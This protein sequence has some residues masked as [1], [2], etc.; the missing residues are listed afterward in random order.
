MPGL[1]WSW[2][3][4]KTITREGKEYIVLMARSTLK[5]KTKNRTEVNGQQPAMMP[6]LGEDN[7][8]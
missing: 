4:T 7:R 2:K 1:G 5:A 6:G 8:D 3:T